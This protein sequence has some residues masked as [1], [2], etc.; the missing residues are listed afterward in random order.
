[1]YSLLEQHND[2]SWWYHPGCTYKTEKEAEEA[3]KKR[4]WWDLERPYKIISHSIAFPQD[5]SRC[6]FDM[7]HYNFAGGNHFILK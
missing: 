7:V 4:F 2:R 5:F 1:M 6:T 3:F